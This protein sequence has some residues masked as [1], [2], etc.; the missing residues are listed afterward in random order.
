M[1]LKIFIQWRDICIVN[2]ILNKLLFSNALQI[3][4]QW[5]HSR[6]IIYIL[7]KLLIYIH[8]ITD[9]RSVNFVS[10]MAKTNVTKPL[11]KYVN[12]KVS[13][14]SFSW[15]SGDV[16]RKTNCWKRNR[17]VNYIIVIIFSWHMF[18]SSPPRGVGKTWIFKYIHIVLY[19]LMP[20]FRL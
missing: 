10:A 6:V 16:R 11:K 18:R 20:P 3:F 7:Y 14:M 4:I 5:R 2:Y 17:Y 12:A 9:L 15:M 13:S 19:Y 1:A 8:N